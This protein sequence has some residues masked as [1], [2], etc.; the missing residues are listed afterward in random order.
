MPIIRN[1]VVRLKCTGCGTLSSAINDKS[2]HE[3][4]AL[5]ERWGWRSVD[6]RDWCGVCAAAGKA[7]P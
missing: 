6:D 1:S 4:R 7:K 3:C 2:D 5:G